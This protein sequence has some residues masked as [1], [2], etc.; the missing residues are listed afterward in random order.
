M[1]LVNNNLNIEVKNAD[2]F[3]KK[4]IGLMFKKN[5]HYGLKFR[6]NGIH[7][8]FMRE[9]I[10]VVLTDKNNKILYIYPSLKKNKILLPKRYVYY[11][12]EFPDNSVKNLKVGEKLNIKSD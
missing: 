10:D 12:Y 9:K 6:C 2:N 11:T 4:T 7:T 3:I 8:F 5:F 1:I